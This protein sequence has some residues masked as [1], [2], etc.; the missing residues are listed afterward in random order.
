MSVSRCFAFG[1]LCLSS[2]WLSL[3]LLMALSIALDRKRHVDGYQFRWQVGNLIR[4]LVCWRLEAGHIFVVQQCDSRSRVT[5]GGECPRHFEDKQGTPQLF[6]MAPWPGTEPRPPAW[7]EGALRAVEVRCCS[8][9][10]MSSTRGGGPR[11]ISAPPT[12]L[13]CHHC[14]L[15]CSCVVARA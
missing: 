2:I 5:A 1:N 9:R 11:R 14:Y 13:A 15:A 7:Q 10:P 3:S 6:C 8:R 12:P 4:L